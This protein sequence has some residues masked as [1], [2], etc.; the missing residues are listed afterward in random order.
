MLNFRKLSCFKK[1]W[2]FENFLVLKSKKFRFK[3]FLGGLITC[4]QLCGNPHW[5]GGDR[6]KRKCKIDRKLIGYY[7]NANGK[8]LK[9]K[10][11][12][13]FKW[14]NRHPFDNHVIKIHWQA[15]MIAST[16][17]KIRKCKFN[18]FMHVKNLMSPTGVFYGR[19]LFLPC[20]MGVSNLI[21]L[22]GVFSLIGLFGFQYNFF[23]KSL[24]FF[25][26]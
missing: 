5:I 22:L 18:I 6:L 11:I 25:E 24:R 12:K 19:F 4:I 10:K 15:P 20:H 9:Q 16:F 17:N 2:I 23:F 3:P 8:K 1:C 14:K 13:L 7:F 26:N 21:G